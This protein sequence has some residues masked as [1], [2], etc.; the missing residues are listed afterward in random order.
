MNRTPGRSFLILTAALLCAGSLCAARAQ[1]QGEPA[2]TAPPAA[3]PSV[4]PAA[5][6]TPGLAPAVTAAGPDI[7]T[8]T[9]TFV[10]TTV[11]GEGRGGTL[12]FLAGG[13]IWV[14]PGVLRP[15]EARY[16]AQTVTCETGDFVRLQPSLSVVFDANE[17]TL[18]IRPELALLPG[19]VLDLGTDASQTA[20][21]GAVLPVF[22]V[23]VRGDLRRSVLTTAGAIG[24]TLTHNAALRLDYQNARVQT[25]GQISEGGVVSSLVADQAPSRGLEAGPQRFGA[26]AAALYDLSTVLSVGVVAYADQ[27][28]PQTGTTL[29][30]TTA[31]PWG[32]S[33][34]RVS[35]LTFTAGSTRAYRLP[36]LVVPLPLDS[37]VSIVVNGSSLRRVRVPAGNLTLRNIPL[38][39]PAGTVEVSILDATGTRTQ[40]FGYTSADVAVAARSLAAQG[41]LGVQGRTAPGT[42]GLMPAAALTGVYGIDERWSVAGEV[43]ASSEQQRAQASVRYTDPVLNTGLSVRYDSRL[44]SPVVL[45]GDATYTRPD[46]RVGVVAAVAP[47]DLRTSLVRA[48]VSLIRPRF[49]TTLGL[50]AAPGTGD[51]GAGLSGTGRLTDRLNL[52]GEGAVTTNRAG[53]LGWRLGVSLNWTPWEKVTVLVGSAVTQA[54]QGAPEA[55]TAAQVSYQPTPA[56]TFSALVTTQPDQP[57]VGTLRYDYNQNVLASVSASTTGDFSVAGA[58]TAA[59][60]AGRVYLTQDQLGHGVL[61]RTGVPRLPLIVN[62]QHVMADARGDALVMVGTAARTVNL[63]PDFERIPFTVSVVEDNREVALAAH[64]VVTVD[65][66]SNFTQNMWVRLVRPDGAPIRYGRLDLPGNPATDDDGWSLIPRQVAPVTVQVQPEEEGAAPCRVTVQA[67]QETYRCEPLP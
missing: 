8:Q 10:D 31:S 56:H 54:G 35:G 62:G 32:V 64:G 23:G 5:P 45:A 61:I 46:W 37:D 63:T 40:R 52:G 41:Q 13:E 36:Q 2:P 3:A 58:A 66:I 6:T 44:R 20:P 50:Q 9:P 67:G 11:N 47:A 49:V 34:Q 65:W 51:Y 43:L 18:D 38:S 28:V 1:T 17:L 15:T 26:E 30:T 48:Q 53:E 42:S 25:Y 14:S 27:G 55:V 39:S 59:W 24:N 21:V 12:A 57:A 29:D 19:G 4:M 22:S 33:T 7:C 16:I 60:V